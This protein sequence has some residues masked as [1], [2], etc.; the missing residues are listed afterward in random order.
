MKFR[1]GVLLILQIAFLSACSPAKAGE[2]PLQACNYTSYPIFFVLA[3]PTSYVDPAQQDDTFFAYRSTGTRAP[4]PLRG[5]RLYSNPIHPDDCLAHFDLD[6][7]LGNDVRRWKPLT[8]DV[9]IKPVFWSAFNMLPGTGTS[10]RWSG[11][12]EQC[13]VYTFL[14]SRSSFKVSS[15]GDGSPNRCALSVDDLRR[16]GYFPGGSYNPSRIEA[17][18]LGFQQ[19]NFKEGSLRIDLIE[20]DALFS[21][22]DAYL[23]ELQRML[24]HWRFYSGPI[25]GVL[26][27]ET[28]DAIRLLWDIARRKENSH[29]AQILLKILEVVSLDELGNRDRAAEVALLTEIQD[30]TNELLN[31][32]RRSKYGPSSVKRPIEVLSSTLRSLTNMLVRI[33]EQENFANWADSQFA[34]EERQFREYIDEL[35]RQATVR[36]NA[37]ERSTSELGGFGDFFRAIASVANA[38]STVLN[39]TN[40][41]RSSRSV[42]S[43]SRS[44][45]GDC[46]AL[47]N[48]M[49]ATQQAYN[50]ARKVGVDVE[51]Q[52]QAYNVARTGYNQCV[53]MQ[54]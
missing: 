40:S 37:R 16:H 50:Q 1:L 12:I 39:A 6:S 24:K 48:H 19:G 29:K 4:T 41:V 3:V 47:Y 35:K 49:Q 11:P 21:K 42:S 15:G 18:V 31:E 52:R 53:S 36:T 14:S 22:D 54:R 8:P 46:S 28:A 20:T 13:V 25:D 2:P 27:A 17:K 30:E 38:A 44:G 51:Y 33:H 23:A 10:M 9:L 26:N 7:L 5:Y 43:P 32:I 34:E 45:A